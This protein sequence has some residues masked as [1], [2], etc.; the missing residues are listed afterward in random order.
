MKYRNFVNLFLT[1][2]TL[3]E[4]KKNTTYAF[5]KYEHSFEIKCETTMND[6]SFCTYISFDD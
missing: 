5:N 4:L 6:F 2:E 3:N 1:F